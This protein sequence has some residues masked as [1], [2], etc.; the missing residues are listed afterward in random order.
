[1]LPTVPGAGAFPACQPI[2]QLYAAAIP[3]STTSADRAS[4]SQAHEKLPARFSGEFRRISSD[5]ARHSKMTGL[6]R[7]PTS[8]D[9]GNQWPRETRV[10]DQPWRPKQHTHCWV[11]L[12]YSTPSAWRI[13]ST[14]ASHL[15]LALP[16]PHGDRALSLTIPPGTVSHPARCGEI[17]PPLLSR[18]NSPACSS[19]RRGRF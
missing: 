9:E 17:P 13:A 7:R 6:T 3:H 5:G 10:R 8:T 12:P 1:M 18:T 2:L 11:S 15:L 4:H 14:N 16:C 19:M